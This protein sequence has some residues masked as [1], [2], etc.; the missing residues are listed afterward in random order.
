MIVGRRNKETADII[1]HTIDFTDWLDSGETIDTVIDN[2]IA[3]G[4]T[5]WS[6]SPFPQPAPYDPSPMAIRSTTVVG[7][8]KQVQVFLTSGTPGNVYTMTLKVLGT[9]G[10]E[11]VVE[12]EI[13]VTGIPPTAPVVAQPGVDVDA[14][15]IT[16]G[17]MEGPLYAFEDPLTDMEV[18]TK[19]YT[20]NL[21][22][23]TERDL[24]DEATARIAEDDVLLAD[25]NAETTRAEAAEAT[26]TTNLATEVARAEA[27]EGVLT[28]NLAA[29]V[30][31]AEAAEATL[32]T[33]LAAEVTRAEAAEAALSSSITSAGTDLTAE[34]A[35]AEAAEATLQ[36]NINTEASTR[37]SAD[38]TLTNNLNAE[39]ARAEAAEAALS[40]LIGAT[41][42]QTGTAS[43][44]GTGHTRVN[45]GTPYG[46]TPVVCVTPLGGGFFVF[47]FNIIADTTGFDIWCSGALGGLPVPEAMTFNWIAAGT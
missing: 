38:T 7:S 2:D 9:S 8:S 17:T 29:E 47:C 23:T 34:I 3:V 28:T 5:G 42:L 4:T 22:L 26:L 19:R 41:A 45:F 33:N 14:L 40:A 24:G 25:I 32:T 44:D 46:S 18:S 1:R 35:R 15:S 31:R 20:D 39:I 16:G 12:L 43:A 13:Q 37:A 30:T 36:T 21:F 10:R 6:S 27:A 11:K